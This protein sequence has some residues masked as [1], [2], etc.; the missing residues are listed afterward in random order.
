M[1]GFVAGFGAEYETSPYE[2]F[3][4]SPM[5]SLNLGQAGLS[6][7]VAYAI[8]PEQNLGFSLNLSYQDVK[9]EGFD[10]FARVSESP[11]RFTDQGR[12][13]AF[14][15]GFT[16]GWRGALTPW[17]QA[18]VA[19][20]SKTWTQ[21]ADEYAGLLPDQGLL[22]LPA[23]YGAGIAVTAVPEWIVALEF[24]RVM[25]ASEKALG[26]GI[27]RLFE[28]R[29][30]LGS[31]EGAGFG[32]NNQNIYKLGLAWHANARTLLRA[33]YSYGTPVIPR[34]QTLFNAL[35]PSLDQKHLT[36]GIT[37]GVAQGWELTGAASKALRNSVR[38][39]DSISGI[40]GGGEV[41]I[42]L[43]TYSLNISVGRS[44]RP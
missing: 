34:S 14:G 32:W 21:R 12:E 33:G 44:F 37:L 40:A 36:L 28:E 23:I 22:E 10:A 5:A 24:Q 35:G 20:R 30:D 39:E 9:V 13:G 16:L 29:E 4:G 42:K 6:S 25:Y 38:G 19:Y 1:T 27:E 3:G 2:R 26:N 11:D 31:D 7:V 8:R 41:D 15:A 17:A 43:R 18:G